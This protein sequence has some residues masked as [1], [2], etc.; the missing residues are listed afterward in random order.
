VEHRCQLAPG[1]SDA[2]PRPEAGP[3]S[4]QSE[5]VSASLHGA[6]GSQ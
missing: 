3:Q 1:G 5:A 6:A 4:A 2:T